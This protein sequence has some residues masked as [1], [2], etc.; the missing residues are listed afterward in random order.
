[1]D[2]PVVS[3]QPSAK[4]WDAHAKDYVEL[5]APLTGHVAR[6]M[7]TIV[8]D[9]LP[10][11]PKLLDIACG[12]GDL[13]VAAAQLCAKWGAGSVFATDISTEMVATTE[14]A[15]ASINAETQCEVR[16]GQ[17]LDLPSGTYDAA[18]SC[19]GIFLFPDRATGWRSAA[20]ALRPGG[21]FVTSVWRGPEFNELAR[22]QMA[23]LMAAL[24]ARLT[25]PSPQAPW[26]G[27]GTA[28][29]L[30]EEVTDSAPFDDP[31]VHIVDAT[32]AIPSPTDMWRGMV[33]NPITGALIAQCDTVEKDK[34]R[35]AVIEAFEQRSG[36][37]DRPLLV[38]ASC[39]VLVARRMA[40]GFN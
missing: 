29:G 19:F 17:A 33:G 37:S 39:H 38:Q 35:H 40:D 5:F 28:D 11:S 20:E 13:A 21:L 14:R 10:A 24:P 12:P 16:D 15:L 8:Q 7:V 32:L 2:R 18:F 23:P 36:G 6:A 34:V 26:A 22:F 31:E 30:I 4:R 3:H 9:R 27:I 25:D 1:M